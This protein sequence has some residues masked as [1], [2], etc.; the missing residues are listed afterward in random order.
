MKFVSKISSTSGICFKWIL[1]SVAGSQN[2]WPFPKPNASGSISNVQQIL[3]Q[4]ERFANRLFSFPFHWCISQLC[5]CFTIGLTVSTCPLKHL[6]FPWKEHTQN[7]LKSVTRMMLSYLA[8]KGL[9]VLNPSSAK[10][11]EISAMSQHQ[12]N[13]SPLFYHECFSNSPPFFPKVTQ[14]GRSFE[15]G[16]Y[17][18]VIW[19]EEV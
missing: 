7:P 15:I 17:F 14:L 19:M 2:S 6:S 4:W 1:S 5:R 16:D 9:D 3:S 13:L 18:G 12:T 10:T 11:F 8:V